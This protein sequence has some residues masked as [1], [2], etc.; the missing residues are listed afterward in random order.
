[1]RPLPSRLLHDLHGQTGV[2]AEQRIQQF[3]PDVFYAKTSDNLESYIQSMG[4][5]DRQ[6]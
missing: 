2:A 6:D 3:I 4:Y 1:M 5:K